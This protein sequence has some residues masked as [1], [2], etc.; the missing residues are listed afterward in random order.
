MTRKFLLFSFSSP[1]H[2]PSGQI[3][4]RTLTKPP[5]DP[6]NTVIYYIYI[7]TTGSPR[8]T[9]QLHDDVTTAPRMLWGTLMSWLIWHVKSRSCVTHVISEKHSGTCSVVTSPWKCPIL[10]LQEIILY[11]GRLHGR[12]ARCVLL[13][14][15]PIPEWTEYC[16]GHAAS[17]G[18]MNRIILKTVYS[19]ERNKSKQV[20]FSQNTRARDTFFNCGCLNTRVKCRG[21]PN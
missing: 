19:E 14:D 10:V 1:G 2:L 17:E 4:C 9:G 15:I 20:F 8:E 21:P 6:D 13:G 3:L 16:S 18:G 12:E 5:T 7:Y 11:L